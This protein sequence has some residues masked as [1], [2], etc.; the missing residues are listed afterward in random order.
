M[1]MK[2]TDI[3]RRRRSIFPSMYTGE[4]ISDEVINEVLELAAYAPTHRLTQPWKFKVFKGEALKKLSNYLGA[5]YK[6]HTPED[7]YS[8]RKYQKTINKPLKSTHVIA[9]IMTR[10]EEQR[11]PEWEEVAAVAMAVQNIWLGF[12]EKRIGCYWS[13]PKSM[14]N[15]GKFLSLKPHERCL[16]MLYIGRPSLHPPMPPR[17]EMDSRI[18]WIIS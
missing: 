9:I 7:K 3:I 13:S 2:A 18:E 1:N 5:Y 15:S 17:D 12:T 10:D 4:E 16:G 6:E 14:I 8:E 11:V